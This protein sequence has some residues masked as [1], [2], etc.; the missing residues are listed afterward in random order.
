MYKYT[1]LFFDL[2][3]TLWDFPANALDT[4]AD[5]FDFFKLQNFGI[6]SHLVFHTS[7]EV[8]NDRLWDL[9]RKGKVDKAF[10]NKERFDLTLKDFGISDEEFAVTL[11]EK[12]IELSPQ[13]TK[14]LPGTLEILNYLSGKYQLHIITN[15]FDEVQY[16]K[17]EFAGLSRFFKTVTTSEEAGYHKPDTRIFK[18]ALQKAEA[19]ASESIMI[20]DDISVDIL[21][22]KEAGLDQ[23]YLNTGNSASDGCATFEIKTLAELKKIFA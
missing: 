2:D 1:H 22:A 21:G 4:F 18:W 14:L 9:Y 19:T 15:G 17:L 6:P 23:V 11:A 12:Y 3:K 20:G 16:R 8:H 7:Y 5:L 10:L 13:K